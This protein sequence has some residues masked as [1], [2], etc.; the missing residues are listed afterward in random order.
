MNDDSTQTVHGY[1]TSLKRQP[2][3]HWSEGFGLTPEPWMKDGKCREEGVDPDLF[4]PDSK[5][6]SGAIPEAKKICAACPVAAQCLAYA[7]RK[8]EQFG[9][10]GGMSTQ[11]I[12]V[13]QTRRRASTTCTTLNCDEP[14]VSRGM[15]GPHYKA[16]LLGVQARKE[17]RKQ[18]VS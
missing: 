6:A 17:A 4:F 3:T 10:W 16:W 12:Q 15:C 7:V 5:A 11:E 18:A 1:N 8:N 14:R 2:D 9:V 13:L